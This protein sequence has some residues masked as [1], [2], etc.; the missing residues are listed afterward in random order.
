MSLMSRKWTVRAEMRKLKP[1]EKTY[2]T[3]MTTG[4][5]RSVEGQRLAEDEDEEQEDGQAEEEMD[6]VARHGD[7]GQDLGREEDFL[8]QVAVDHQDVGRLDGGGGEPDPGQDA[9]EEE[10]G[11]D[12]G[13]RSKA[14]SRGL[15]MKPKTTV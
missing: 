12:Q 5:R 2:W 13:L 6:E 1:R 3:R 14:G 11:I 8:D 15:R 7:D 9:A 10:E 4:S